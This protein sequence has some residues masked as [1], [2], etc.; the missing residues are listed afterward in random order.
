MNDQETS[1]RAM[2]LL[3]DPNAGAGLLRRRLARSLTEIAVA[4]T[5]IAQELRLTRQH[6]EAARHADTYAFENPTAVP[7]PATIE[8][9]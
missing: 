3:T 1:D 5:I 8:G 6:R 4:L 9:P 7:P 2:L